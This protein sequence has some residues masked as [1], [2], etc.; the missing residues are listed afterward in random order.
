ML[1]TITLLAGFGLFMNSCQKEKPTFQDP[2]PRDTCSRFDDE[3]KGDSNGSKDPSESNVTGLGLTVQYYSSGGKKAATVS[4]DAKV[5]IFNKFTGDT[6]VK[7]K[8]PENSRNISCIGDNEPKVYIKAKPG[9]YFKKKTFSVIVDTFEQNGT[10]H[11]L[12]DG[13]FQ[14]E[15]LPDCNWKNEFVVCDSVS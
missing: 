9:E 12:N 11:Y 14:V 2:C 6:F 15:S 7:N 1:F 13:S 10:K 5:T 3:P 4:Q 8:T